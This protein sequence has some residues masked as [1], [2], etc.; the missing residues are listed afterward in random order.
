MPMM[1]DN[2]KEAPDMASAVMVSIRV[3]QHIGNLLQMDP[4]D[5]TVAKLM[6]KPSDDDAK[7]PESDD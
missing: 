5:L 3:T 7:Q 2:K 1:Y 6:A 4:D